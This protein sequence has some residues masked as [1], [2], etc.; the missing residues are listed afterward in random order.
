MNLTGNSSGTTEE[1]NS[2]FT[3]AEIVI[4]NRQLLSSWRFL[5]FSGNSLTCV[6]FC[7]RSHLCN[8]TNVAIVILATSDVLSAVLVMPFL[9]ASFIRD[10]W[11]LGQAACLFNAYLDDCLVRCDDH[12]DGVY[13]I[14][15]LLPCCKTIPSALPKV[16]ANLSC[17]FD[18]CG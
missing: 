9:L 10:G 18:V 17:Y 3:A 8:P 13:S 14:D 15:S 7:R 4:K 2:Y 6:V 12:F 11:V 1:A 5:A 16:K